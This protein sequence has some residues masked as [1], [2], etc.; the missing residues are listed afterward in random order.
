MNNSTGSVWLSLTNLGVLAVSTNSDVAV[1]NTG[2]LFLPQ[3]PETLGHDADGNLTRDD[4]WNCT[5]DA[6]NRLVRMVSRTDTPTNSWRSLT[7]G[8]DPQGRRISKTVSNWVGSAWQLVSD[9][10]FVYDGWNCLATLNSSFSLLH[11]FTWGLDLSG[12]MQGAGGVGGLLWLDDP[13]DTNVTQFV[14]FDGNGNV[15]ALVS[16]TNGA[17]TAN[18]EYGPFG[19]VIRSTGAM[20]KANPFRFSTKYQDDESD[21]L[22]YGYRYLNTSTGRWLSRDPIS[23]SEFRLLNSA[24]RAALLELLKR[25]YVHVG[26]NPINYI[27]IFGLCDCP[28]KVCCPKCEIY[29]TAQAQPSADAGLDEM[30]KAADGLDKLELLLGV[31]G[32][33]ATA[34][35]DV[36]KALEMAAEKYLGW[37]HNKAG[38]WAAE[39]AAK[40]VE[41]INE[42]DFGYA[43]FT[44]IRYR[45]CDG[46]IFKTWEN[47]DPTGW[48]QWTGSGDFQGVGGEYEG[49]FDDKLDAYKTAKTACA[50]AIAEWKKTNKGN[51]YEPEASKW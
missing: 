51:L 23:D 33:G 27:D 26:N 22:Y 45:K 39:Y 41:K 20:A 11:S 42:R 17:V 14:A 50:Q 4:R 15:A 6:E 10:R 24:R 7:F 12:S 3:T 2:H 16:A 8:Y 1:T 49:R 35:V 48:K 31:I 36:K 47:Q 37:S 40:L 30:V 44:R 34:A 32:T 28:G 29:V 43:L 21:L 9:E 5:W 18:Y 13:V 38:A 19:E 46:V 25:L